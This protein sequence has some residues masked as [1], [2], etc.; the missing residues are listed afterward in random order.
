MWCSRLPVLA[1]LACASAWV[2]SASSLLFVGGT[3]IGFD[4]GT[5]HLKVYRSGK[6]LVTDDRIF[7]V[8]EANDTL[9]ST[10]DN[11]YKVINA[12]GKIITPGF[13]DTHRH[14]WQTA[15]KTLASNTSLVEYFGRYGE[16]AA[17]GK[18]TSED[19]YLGQLAGL[20]E[21][22]NAGV[23]TTLDHAHH[24]WSLETSEA[25]LQ[26]SIDSNARVFWS[27][28]FHNVTGWNVTQQYPAFREIASKATFKGTHTSLGIAYDYFGPDPN[29]SEVDTIAGLAKFV[30]GSLYFTVACQKQYS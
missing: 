13:V 7:G 1:A 26:A 21:C 23:T 22:L 10:V 17:A 25:G 27:F 18:F 15:F 24:T 16:F 30:H 5:Q 11:K 20:Y 19:V 12:T 6:L 3:I 4:Q 29:M 8:Y 14:G 9:P 28:A 2:T